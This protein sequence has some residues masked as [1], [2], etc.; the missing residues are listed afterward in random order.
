M[1]CLAYALRFWEKNPKYKLYY[2]PGHVINSDVSIPGPDWLPAEEYGYC[3][4]VSSFD[5]LLDEYEQKLLKKYFNIPSPGQ[6]LWMDYAEMQACNELEEQ[7]FK[8]WGFLRWSMPKKGLGVGLYNKIKSMK[9]TMNKLSL[10]YFVVLLKTEDAFDQYGYKQPLSPIFN[11]AA[12]HSR[13][14]GYGNN[15][16]MDAMNGFQIDQGQRFRVYDVKIN[17]KSI[18][19]NPGENE[20][21]NYIKEGN[22]VE[23]LFIEAPK[24]ILK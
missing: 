12:R 21:R 8:N 9:P 3:Y 24:D 11:G 13:E 10:R 15:F 16:G 7:F 5:G 17:N 18:G 1:N 14:K 6:L 19:R 20:I 2:R 23:V 22:V 4:F